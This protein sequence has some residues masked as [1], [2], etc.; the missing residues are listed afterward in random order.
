M[1]LIVCNAFLFFILHCL[2]D[3]EE[4]DVVGVFSDKTR[5][6]IVIRKSDISLKT[7]NNSNAPPTE[8]LSH[9]QTCYLSSEQESDEGNARISHNDLERKRRTDLRN[10]FQCLR[11]CIPSLEANERVAKIVILRRAS[12][13]IS[14]LRKEEEKLIAMKSY[15]KKRNAE[16][17]NKLTKLTKKKTRQ[18]KQV[19]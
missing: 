14:L 10:R 8:L 5:K 18:K 7:K 4:I 6:N 2:T 19:N 15:E 12:E 16:L 17:L 9:K 11:K 13:L 1:L 3:E